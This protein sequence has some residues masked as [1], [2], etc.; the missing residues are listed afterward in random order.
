MRLALLIGPMLL[1]VGG[2]SLR[3]AYAQGQPPGHLPVWIEYTPDDCEGLISIEPMCPCLPGIGQYTTHWCGLLARHQA[4]GL[5]PPGRESWR[6]R[7]LMYE[8]CNDGTGNAATMLANRPSFYLNL[9]GPSLS[10]DT[11]CSSSLH[12]SSRSSAARR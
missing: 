11:A 6:Y 2:Q 12:R 9:T 5:L 10:V 3:T 7:P 1:L 4:L 8:L